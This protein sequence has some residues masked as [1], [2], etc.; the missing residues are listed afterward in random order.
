[1]NTR[2]NEQHFDGERSDAMFK[3]AITEAFTHGV[4][5]RCPECSCKQDHAGICADCLDTMMEDIDAKRATYNL[6]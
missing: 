2:P 4:G 5:H 1:M 6:N 3:Q